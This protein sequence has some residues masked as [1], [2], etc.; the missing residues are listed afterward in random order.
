MVRRRHDDDV[1]WQL[2]QLHQKEGHHALDFTSFM[3]IATLFANGIELIEEKHA[4]LCP[5]IIEQFA[6]PGICLTQITA[7]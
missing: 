7:D 5:H 4:W 2:I 6:K 3:R 1:A